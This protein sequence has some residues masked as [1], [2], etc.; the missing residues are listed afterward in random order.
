MTPSAVL[1][2]PS[3]D[4]AMMLKYG[5]PGPRYTSYPTAPH[6]HSGFTNDSYVEEIKHSDD[7]ESP[8]PLSLYFH[9]PFCRSV[10][11]FCGCNVHRTGDPGLMEKYLDS[12][13]LEL[14]SIRRLIRSDR[15]VV[16]VHWGGG[17]PTFMPAPLLKKLHDGIF[18]AFD[19]GASPEI[20]VEL[21]PREITE[22]HYGFMA[23]SR[24]NRFSIGV[25]DLDPAVQK[26]IHRTQSEELVSASIDRLRK[27]GA[28]SISVDLVY[29]LPFQTAESFRRTLDRIAALGP[30]RIAVFNFAYLPDLFPMQKAI[31][32]GTLPSPA[33]KLRILETTIG[34]LTSKGYVHIGMD[35]FAR[36]G[37]ELALALRDRTLS[38]NF[39]GYTT[40]GGCDLFGVG[41][42]SIGQI[43]RAYS[44]NIK[45]TGLYMASVEEKGLAVARGLKL[46]GEDMMRRDVISRIMCHFVL[47]KKEI[48]ER[49]A[50]HFDTHFEEALAGLVPMKDDG[51][52]ELHADRIEV[53]PPGRLLVRNIAMAFDGYIGKE[54]ERERFSRTI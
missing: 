15:K 52:L 39:Q 34:S 30:D 4:A 21:D 54:G 53:K 8:P 43:G 19:T 51:L 40:N 41:A 10:C 26:A 27:I 31:R 46:T 17:T 35:H 13:L 23:E 50:V 7:S 1:E 33:E 11:W 42:T 38:R 18:S 20:G 29:G 48:E 14:S 3:F 16:Q 25:Q 6:F 49:Y 24:F 5:K 2:T 32:S 36:P 28:R 45:D 44:Q 12:M 47:Y 37:D 22:E 9:L